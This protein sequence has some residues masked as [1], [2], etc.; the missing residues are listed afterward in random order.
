MRTDRGVAQLAE[1]QTLNLEV[2]GSSPS[3][4][5][6]K[7]NIHPDF[8]L[9]LPSGVCV[10]T[11]EGIWRLTCTDRTKGRSWRL[12]DSGVV[13]YE[14]EIPDAEVLEILSA[15]LDRDDPVTR[16]WLA[17]Q[18]PKLFWSQVPTDQI[19]AFYNAMPPVAGPWQVSGSGDW[20]YRY[21]QVARN[22]EAVWAAAAKLPQ[23]ED[24]MRPD[25]QEGKWVTDDGPNGL[26]EPKWFDT[27]EQAMAF[28]DEHLQAHGVRLL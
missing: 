21:W 10:R 28:L 14:A 9:D 8:L 11:N 3:S 5:A 1:P 17:S 7:G 4:P 20:A 23:C 12:P 22:S 24:Q 18:D 27:K 13:V 2:E 25:F 19:E 6:T 15:G 16:A 26:P